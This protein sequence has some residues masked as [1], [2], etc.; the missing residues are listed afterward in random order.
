MFSI[1]HAKTRPSVSWMRS[2]DGD[3]PPTSMAELLEDLGITRSLSR[4]R[5]SNDKPYSE[6]NFKTAK[7][8]PDYPA[9]FESLDEVP[10]GA[11][12]ANPGP[13]PRSGWSPGEARGSA[14]PELVAWVTSCSNR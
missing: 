3:T 4:P 8:R 14:T 2:S 10:D 9:R 11:Y 5:T 6:G 7:Y 12:S 1:E 13:V